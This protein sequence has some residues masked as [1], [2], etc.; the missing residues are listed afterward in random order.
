[1]SYND[2]LISDAQMANTMCDFIEFLSQ[3]LG[4]DV[5]SEL[6]NEYNNKINNNT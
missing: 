1:M 2:N 3:K 4:D 5:V 6:V